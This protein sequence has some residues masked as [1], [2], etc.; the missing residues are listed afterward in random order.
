M[1]EILQQIEKLES[2]EVNKKDLDNKQAE[3]KGKETELESKKNK[4]SMSMGSITAPV[5]EEEIEKD[6]TDLNQ[7]RAEYASS[8]KEARENFE[9]DKEELRNLVNKELSSYKRRGEIE[10]AKQDL[11]TQKK[12]VKAEIKQKEE[13]KEQIKGDLL[14]SQDRYME[15]AD[16]AKAAID[17]ATED[18]QAGKNV[19][20]ANLR[21]AREDFEAN[22]KKVQDIDAQIDAIDND[23]K[24][25]VDMRK[26]ELQN[27]EKEVN[28]YKAIEDHM[29]EIRDLEHLRDSIG[30]MSFE[31]VDKIKENVVISDIRK[32][33]NE[34]QI[35]EK[36][37][38][39]EDSSQQ[40][41]DEE[42][43]E[44]DEVYGYL[45]GE[46]EQPQHSLTQQQQ[47]PKKQGPDSAPTQVLPKV[48]G[49]TPRKTGNNVDQTQV[50]KPKIKGITIG[51]GIVIECENGRIESLEV[52]Q[53]VAKKISKSGNKEK[54][55]MLRKVTGEKNLPPNSKMLAKIDANILYALQIAGD[56]GIDQETLRET[57]GNYIMALMGD[58]ES[59]NEIAGL[60]TYDRTGMDYWKPSTFI[61][62][63][64]NNRYYKTLEQHMLEA[65]EFVKIKS[66][67][68]GK[69]LRQ[70][71]SSRKVKKL[72]AANQV[73]EDNQQTQESQ[74]SKRS[75]FIEG[76]KSDYNRFVGNEKNEP[77]SSPFKDVQAKTSE[78]EKDSEDK[79]ER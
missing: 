49:P 28:S 37:S 9:K 10:Q 21:L 11:E 5:L 24:A 29:D 58:S 56:N 77:I 59:K 1:E 41:K 62:K 15:L 20:Q 46:V 45:E 64:I 69:T 8:N 36:A 47:Q 16:E 27:S 7:E 68:K 18:F 12:Q 51:K 25:E 63:I 74:K 19:D 6:E 70:M 73:K 30:S 26:V 38:K 79:G 72:N 42:N 60:I 65:R 4:L 13:E 22:N 53:K 32:K 43:K 34:K 66:D 31:N 78:P 35:A 33:E 54:L 23:F 14:D 57:A 67:E 52:K 17:R 2:Y 44:N 50:I 39:G 76:I 55:E 3:I 61:D 75:S 48:N 40:E 71:L